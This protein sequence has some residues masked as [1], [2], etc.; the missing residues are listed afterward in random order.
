MRISTAVVFTLAY[1]V[2]LVAGHPTLNENNNA[3]VDIYTHCNRPGVFALTFDDGPSKYSWGLSK[4]LKEQGIKATFFI[5]GKNSVDVL[6]DSTLTDEGE[7]TYLEVIKSYYDS[8]HEI[9]SHTL[10]HQNLVGL[11][12]EE[13]KLQMNTQSDIIY[14]AIGKRPALMRPPEG[15]IDDVSSKVLKELGYND[16]MWDIDTKDWEHNGLNAEQERVRKVM[17]NDVANTSMGHICL[18]HDI[19]EDTV[20]HLVPWLITYVK[21]KGYEFVTV[22]NCIGVKPYHEV[23]SF[24][25]NNSTLTST[26]TITSPI[27]KLI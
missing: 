21:E 19:H 13:I 25:A 7:K 1:A 2:S 14:Q 27:N 9:A 18:E 8:G 22:S 5:N 16:I 23:E 4:S 12:E 26:P 3:Q 6:K 20:Q 11:S 10:N 24:E 15:V 17:E